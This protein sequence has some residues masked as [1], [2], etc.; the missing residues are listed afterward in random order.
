LSNDFILKNNSISIVIDGEE[1][2]Y[3]FYGGFNQP[4]I[5]WIDL[6]LD[7]DID[8][9][10]KDEGN[11]LRFFE[12]IGDNSQ[13]DFLLK[14]TNFQNIQIGNWFNF[15]DFDFDGD[16]DLV[17]QNIDIQSGSY[18]AMKYYQNIDMNFQLMTTS[19]VTDLDEIVYSESISTPTFADIDFDGDLDFFSGNSSNGSLTF[20]ENIGYENSIP[21]FQYVTNFWEEITIIGGLNQ[22]HGAS[23]ITFIDLDDDGDL[24]L[25]WGDYFQQ[26]LYIIWNIGNEFYPSM[27]IENI[28]SEF[29]EN[30]PIET[31]GQ[32]M[33]SFADLDGDGDND[34]FVT[35]LFGAYGTQYVNNFYYYQ[36]FGTVS[37]PIYEYITSNYLATLD[38]YTDASP[39]FSDI[40]NDGDLD[41]FVGTEIDYSTFPFRG[42]IKY[43]QN[44]GNQNEPIFTLIDPYFLGTNIGTNLAPELVDIDNDNDNDMF[45]GEWNGKIKFYQNNGTP[46]NFNFDYLGELNAINENNVLDIIDLSGRSSPRFLDIDNDNDYD[47]FIGT[48]NGNITFYENTGTNISYEFTFITDQYNQIE[49]GKNA[50]PDFV[51][52]DLDDD[53]D[54]LVGSESMGVSLYRNIGSIDSADYVFDSTYSFISGQNIAPSTSNL[55]SLDTLDVVFGL[56]TGGL[57]H[58][59]LNLCESGDINNDQSIDVIDVNLIVDLV[60]F[61]EFNLMNFLCRADLDDNNDINIFDIILLVEIILNN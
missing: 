21:I 59:Q 2:E 10:L 34:L 28:I 23:A 11:Y 9:F 29:P 38:F 48:V 4:K 42:R 56:S 61:E 16:L 19:L 50:K 6:D 51:D 17:T 27:D 25:S 3:P 13:A 1:L 12:N 8:L 33:P 46:E 40:D 22:R 57:F 47:L 36:N 41:F 26:S 7:N 60:L 30:N 5:Q 15:N 52:I 31:A 45:I 55:F 49:L 35:V 37:N 39:A 20:Y 58:V 43:F 54:L 18:L 24:D 14:S 44:T 53:F 32:N